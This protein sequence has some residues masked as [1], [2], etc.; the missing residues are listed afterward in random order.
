VRFETPVTQSKMISAGASAR[1][2]GGDARSR[3]SQ[4]KLRALV[5]ASIKDYQ[6]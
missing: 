4:N 1:P 3:N 2:I 6:R 5:R